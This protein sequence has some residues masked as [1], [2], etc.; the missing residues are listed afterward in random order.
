M[1]LTELKWILSCFE[2][3]SGMRINY[4]K[5]ELVPMNLEDHVVANISDIFGCLVGA[6][7]IRCLGVSLHYQK[8]KRED[9]QPLV[10]K[11]LKKIAGW[12]GKL[13]SNAGR[14]V[15]IKTCLASVHVYLMSFFKPDVL[16]RVPQ[17]GPGSN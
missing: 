17:V 1:S 13:L 3:M 14:I 12:R 15:L 7:P 10:D 4:S 5:S 8:L 6:F 9:L 16:L 2:M 11:I